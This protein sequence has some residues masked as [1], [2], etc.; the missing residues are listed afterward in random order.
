MADHDGLF[1]RAMSVPAHAAG[2]LRSLLPES[3]TST[4]DLDHATLESGTFVDP[5]LQH[6]HSDLLFR[7]PLRHNPSQSACVYFLLE[8]QSEPDPVMP[9]RVFNYTARIYERLMR[10]EPTPRTLPAVITVVVH[11]G[12]GGWGQAPRKLTD[13]LAGLD[14]VPQL[15]PYVP[16]ISFVL[17]DLALVDDDALR[18]RPLPPF[19]RVALWLLRDGRAIE[20]LLAHLTSWAREV[21]R[22]QRMTRPRRCVIFCWSAAL[23]THVFASACWTPPHSW[24][25]P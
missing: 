19:P 12:E 9:W 8:H 13:M 24:N 20:R 11:H 4:L 25:R 10:E 7:I 14:A 3:V 5:E 2:E 23:S 22:S 17:D 6:R 15:R 21:G 16:E 1:K 18:A